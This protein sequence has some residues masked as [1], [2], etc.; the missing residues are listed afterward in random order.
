MSLSTRFY[1]NFRHVFLLKYNQNYLKLRK[2]KVVGSL[3]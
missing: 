3:L 1:G 2:N